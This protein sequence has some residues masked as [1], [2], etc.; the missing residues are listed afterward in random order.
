MTIYD[1]IYLAPHLDDVALSCGG[2]IF[3]RTQQGDHI[4]IVTIT[5]GDAPQTL[6]P[7]AEAMHRSMQLDN[8]PVAQ[9]RAE[10]AAACQHLG[11]SYLHLD[12][13]DCIYRCDPKTGDWLYQSDDE[14]FGTVHPA[15]QTRLQPY[16]AALPPH[17]QLFAPL[18][19]GN[20]VDHQLVTQAVADRPVYYYPDYPYTQRSDFVAPANCE[21]IPLSAAAIDARLTAI[22][23][24]ESQVPH[25]FGSVKTNETMETAVRAEIAAHGGELFL[26]PLT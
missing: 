16:I 7:F 23:M 2:Q 9:R 1:A 25:L 22:R 11:A 24:Y 20:H 10:D 5:A 6:S 12:V 19:I 14:I 15:E 8:N 3:Q 17:K 13:R 21:R 4:L 18:S 26:P